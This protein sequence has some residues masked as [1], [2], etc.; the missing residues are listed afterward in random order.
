MLSCLPKPLRLY[1]QLIRYGVCQPRSSAKVL[2]N[3]LG[4]TLPRRLRDWEKMA[5]CSEDFLT[6]NG[7]DAIIKGRFTPPTA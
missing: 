1:Q 7:L 6:K 2:V 3:R 4:L 5:K